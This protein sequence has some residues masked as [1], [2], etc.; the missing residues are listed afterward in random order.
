[1]RMNRINQIENTIRQ[2]AAWIEDTPELQGDELD[3][4][5]LI[6]SGY[7]MGEVAEELRTSLNQVIYISE[8]VLEAVKNTQNNEIE[9]ER[10]E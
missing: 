5:N 6:L 4:C 9:V 1:M 8:T 2:H 3:V 10:E 7:S